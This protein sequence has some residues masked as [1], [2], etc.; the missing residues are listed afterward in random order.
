MSFALS[1]RSI[2]RAAAVAALALSAAAVPTASAEAANIGGR[3]VLING[4]VADFGAGQHLF[5]SPQRSADVDF[6]AGPVDGS[7]AVSARVRG[8]LYFDA[9]DPGCARVTIKF[10]DRNSNVLETRQPSDVCGPGGDANASANK[11]LVIANFSHP[12]LDKVKVTTRHVVG[13]S[14]I[15]GGTKTV[16]APTGRAF[17]TRIDSRTAD[18]GRGAH[19]L[20]APARS[21]D[22]AFERRSNGIRASVGGTLY[23]DS[24]L[25][26]GCARIVIDY[27]A[28]DGDRLERETETDCG[29]GGDAND[30]RNHSSVN[31]SFTNA[32]LSKVRIKVG[33]LAGDSFVNVTTKTFT[34]NNA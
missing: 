17:T 2:R 5:T 8:T 3:T 29:P 6:A 27:L 19:V 18:F 16:T 23:Y 11:R 10:L 15:G 32:D 28:A 9:I 20:G 7:F 14:L 22:V 34:F 13:G 12:A 26:A 4:G 30:S 25:Q 1:T 33:T 21:G 24:L 31:D